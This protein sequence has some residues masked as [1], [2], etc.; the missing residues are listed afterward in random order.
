MFRCCSDFLQI[1]YNMHHN[2]VDCQHRQDR[3]GLYTT[4]RG[5]GLTLFCT[6]N[7]T[8]CCLLTTSHMNASYTPGA[9]YRIGPGGRG[10]ER[11]RSY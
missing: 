6:H 2:L 3:G 4:G 11:E 10:G 5:L 7:F 9:Q 8:M 1:V